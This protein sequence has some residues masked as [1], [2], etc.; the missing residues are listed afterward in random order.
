VDDLF[1]SVEFKYNK[2][3]F[4]KSLTVYI[5]NANDM[6]IVRFENKKHN[7]EDDKEE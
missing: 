3:K 4:N 1:T 5:E 7:E 2:C 6:K